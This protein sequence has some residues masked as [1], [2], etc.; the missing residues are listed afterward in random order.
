MMVNAMCGFGIAD[1]EFRFSDTISSYQENY[2]LRTKAVL[3]GWNEVDPLIASVTVNSGVVVGAASTGAYAFDTGAPFP[4][5]S[6]LSLTIAGSIEG[7]GGAAGAAGG[8]ALRA[9][10]AIT[11]NNTGT[12][13]G[14]GGGGGNGESL[15]VWQ[16]AGDPPVCSSLG[17][18]AAGGAG[19]NGAGSGV[20]AAPGGAGGGYAA[21]SGTTGAG[22]AGG[23]LG[24]PGS[25]GSYG[26]HFGCYP[27]GSPGAEG[28][29][30]SAVVGNSYITWV[31]TGT[32]LGS[33]S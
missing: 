23:A 16:F 32:R 18:T 25:A 9:Q 30:G 24:S 17:Y 8:P 6:L 3:A 13:G 26:A 29:A 10:H 2:N 31:A 11:I 1:N 5:G 27:G 14:G 20:A 22:G 33:V 28:A 21:D 19:G 12:I 4:P 7:K 15:A